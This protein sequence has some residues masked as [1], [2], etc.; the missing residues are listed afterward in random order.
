[1]SDSFRTAADLIKV[2]DKNLAE[3]NMTDLFDR[4]PLIGALPVVEPS[5]G[6][7]HKYLVQDAAPVIGFRGINQG[8]EQTSGTERLVTISLKIVEASFDLDRA[9]VDKYKD[10]PEACILMEARKNLRAALFGTE[11]QI[12]NGIAG[13]NAGGFQGFADVLDHKDDAMVVDAA[14]TT[15]GTGSSVYLIHGSADEGVAL[16]M[17]EQIKIDEAYPSTAVDGNGKKYNSYRVPVYGWMGVQ[18]GSSTSFARICNLTADS[19][20]GLT[21]DLLY[22]A[23]SLLPAGMTPNLIVMGRRSLRQ[24]QKSRTATNATGAP[25][26]VPTEVPGLGR[27]VLTDGIGETETLLAAAGT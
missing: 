11:T 7:E 10:G 1:M 5:N 24:L 13:N 12:I 27:I 26:P 23:A 4:S 17:D 21:D 9:Y 25:A 2:N 3:V 15:A 22:D 16:V 19:D 14:G 18:V 8:T 6:T 20:K